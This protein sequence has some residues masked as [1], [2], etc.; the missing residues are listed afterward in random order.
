MHALNENGKKSGHLSV[1]ARYG[2]APCQN[3]CDLRLYT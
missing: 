1:T 2:L 3:H